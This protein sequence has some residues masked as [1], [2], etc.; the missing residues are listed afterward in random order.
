MFPEDLLIF[1][2]SPQELQELIIKDGKDS[3]GIFCDQGLLN[4]QVSDC[5]YILNM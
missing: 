5:T 2:V 3:S 1:L 4:L